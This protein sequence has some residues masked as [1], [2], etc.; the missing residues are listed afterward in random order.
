MFKVTWKKHQE[1]VSKAIVLN[2]SE[3]IMVDSMFGELNIWR[4]TLQKGRSFKKFFPWM[5][6]SFQ[7][8]IQK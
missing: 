6:Q 4:G 2:I 5:L 8:Y 7:N 3:K 1:T